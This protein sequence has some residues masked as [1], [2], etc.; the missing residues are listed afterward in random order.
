MPRKT[1]TTI[2]V[3]ANRAPWNELVLRG[4]RKVKT[5]SFNW[6][7][8]GPILLYTSTNRQDDWGLQDYRGTHKGLKTLKMADIPKGFIVGYAT[9]VDVV[10]EGVFSGVY[11]SPNV[12]LYD[13][14]YAEDPNL[15]DSLG[16][17]HVVIIENPKRFVTPI[18]FKP[19]PG[20]IRIMKAP[21]SYLKRPTI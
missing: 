15:V 20:A 11:P 5:L 6:K 1:E 18:P 16:Q 8:R 14:F 21:A 13:K 19:K 4:K 17:S 10:E 2:P 9:V 7:Y 12:G 3:F